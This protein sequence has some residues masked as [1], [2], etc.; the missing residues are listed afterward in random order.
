[1][2]DRI[3]FSPRSVGER[4]RQQL[5]EAMEKSPDLDA[6]V[7]SRPRA[8][9]DKSIPVTL[10]FTSQ[11]SHKSLRMRT[12]GDE[13]AAQALP[14]EETP[15]T[16][17]IRMAN[18]LM[19]EKMLGTGHF[20]NASDLARQIGVSKKLVSDLLAMLNLPVDEIERI[21]FSTCE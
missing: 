1:M 7:S 4:N 19:L 10:T 16:E 9:W 2:K 5:A 8:G 13:L 21:L 3:K 14:R 11:G 17:A 20:T 18:A 12:I 6:I 15:S